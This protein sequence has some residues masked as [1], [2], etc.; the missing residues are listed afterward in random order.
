M[1]PTSYG[2]LPTHRVR[3]IEDDG[4]VGAEVV[5][6]RRTVRYWFRPGTLAAQVQVVGARPR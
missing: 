1:L 2:E 3:L 4:R 5:G 6:P